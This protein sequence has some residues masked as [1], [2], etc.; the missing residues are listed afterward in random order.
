M[1]GLYPI[2][3]R[4]I[5][6]GPFSLVRVPLEMAAAV[7]FAFSITG[8]LGAFIP[9]AASIGVTFNGSPTL[10]VEQAISATVSFAFSGTPTLHIA[11]KP[12]QLA[13]I[14]QSYNLRAARES[15]SAKALPSSHT[16]RGAR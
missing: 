4:A 1:L 8:R 13:A 12:I 11:G 3:S 2:G 7:S 10:Y 6:G 15:Y 9:M 16:I 14:P 5:S